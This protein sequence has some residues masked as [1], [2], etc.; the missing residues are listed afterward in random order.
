M[1]NISSTRNAVFDALKSKTYV[2]ISPFEVERITQYMDVT[3]VSEEADLLFLFGTMLP[4]P[5]YM[6]ADAFAR[7]RIKY[8][9]LTGGNNRYTGVN[10][11]ESHLQILLEGGVPR[12]RIM[13]ENE[14]RN[15]R[16]NVLFA[17]PH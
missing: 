7:N 12:E 8:I 13:V 14:S 9:V 2:L 10:E 15:T 17:L 16:E 1:D 4:A 3:A 6:A 11:A 5:A